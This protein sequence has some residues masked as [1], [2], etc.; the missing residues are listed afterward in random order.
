MGEQT[1]IPN[2]SKYDLA[3]I[4]VGV[5]TAAQAIPRLWKST[6]SPDIKKWMESRP[7]LEIVSYEH[8]LARVNNEDENFKR[9]WDRFFAHSTSGTL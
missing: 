2:I 1:E 5:V 4:K 3:V 8:M 7:M 6:S 9:A